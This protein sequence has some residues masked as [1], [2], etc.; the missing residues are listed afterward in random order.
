MHVKTMKNNEK[1]Y[2]QPLSFGTKDL[3]TVCDSCEYFVY[4]Y[5]N[6]KLKEL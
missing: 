6:F 3:T 1:A 5:V 2:N 4:I